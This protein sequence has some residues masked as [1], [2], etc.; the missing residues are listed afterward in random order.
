MGYVLFQFLF[1]CL[2][3]HINYFQMLWI[4]TMRFSQ[5]VFIHLSIIWVI[6]IYVVVNGHSC[7]QL[8]RIP[9]QDNYFKKY[10]SCLYTYAISSM[11]ILNATFR[12]PHV[13]AYFGCIT[14]MYNSAALSLMSFTHGFHL[15]ECL[16]QDK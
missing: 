10:I 8:S 2:C 6:I 13:D 3:H 15:I 1:I 9:L 11:P 7:N 16:H 4:N 14:R 12:I 5:F